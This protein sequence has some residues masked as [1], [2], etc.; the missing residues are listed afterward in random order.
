MWYKLSMVGIGINGPTYIYGG[1]KAVLLNASI[2]E[3]VLKKKS[4]SSEYHFVYEGSSS[5]EW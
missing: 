3:S 1:N 5:D 4:N 2:S